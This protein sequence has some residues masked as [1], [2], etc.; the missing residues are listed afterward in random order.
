MVAYLVGAVVYMLSHLLFD[1]GTLDVTLLILHYIVP[2][3]I[4]LD[5]LLFDTKGHMTPTGPLVWVVLPLAYVIYIMVSVNVFGLFMGAL[6]LGP[7]RYPYSF[8][9]VDALGA[10]SVALFIVAMLVAFIALGYVYFA[11]DHALAKRAK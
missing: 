4:V 2:I 9:D 10:G 6:K 1:N 7:S 3:G 8:F 11:I 5:W